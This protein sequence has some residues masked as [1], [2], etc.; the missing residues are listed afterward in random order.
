MVDTTI[1][2]EQDCVILQPKKIGFLSPLRWLRLGWQD[3]SHSRRAS[4]A[5]GLITTAMGWAV[6]T[7]TSDNLYLFTA[8][9]SG[10]LLIGPLMASGVYELSRR[11]ETGQPVTFDASLAGLKEHGSRLTRFAS[12]LLLFVFV[13][14]GLSSLLF[15]GFFGATVPILP[16]VTLYQTFWLSGGPGFI[17]TYSAVG[18]VIALVVFALS[19]VS[20][21]LMMDRKTEPEVAMLTS[22]RAVWLNIPTMLHWAVLLVALTLVGF[23]TQLW[24]MIIIIP[25]LGH[26]TWHAYKDSVC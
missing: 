8:A 26:A 16:G 13:W 3:F 18:G 6:L 11:K 9:T 19:V 20:V 1:H 12:I 14:L 5:Y 7:F 22:A 24:G 4:L 10:F 15:K 25:W 2:S 17:L 21:P 23:A